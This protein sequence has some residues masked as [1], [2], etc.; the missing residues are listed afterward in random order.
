MS[1]RQQANALELLT[2]KLLPGWVLPRQW[3][4]RGV[5]GVQAVAQ[6]CHDAVPSAIG[7]DGRE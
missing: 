6:R 7:A 4:Q 2:C 3:R 5:R 1:K